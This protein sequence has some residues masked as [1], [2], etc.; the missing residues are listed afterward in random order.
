MRD[1]GLDFLKA[2][3]DQLSDGHGCGHVSLPSL[4]VISTAAPGSPHSCEPARAGA[5]ARQSVVAAGDASVTLYRK[6]CRKAGRGQ[7]NGRLPLRA[8]ERA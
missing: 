2:V 4:V 3:L 7:D 5:S 6:H 8:P 1:L